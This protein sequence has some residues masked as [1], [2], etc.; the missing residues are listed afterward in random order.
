MLIAP[1]S[2]QALDP[3][4]TEGDIVRGRLDIAADDARCARERIQLPLTLADVV[5]L[6]LCNNPQTRSLWAAAR[7]QAAQVGV[8]T[9]AYLP[10][11]SAQASVAQNVVTTGD[12][13]QDTSSSKSVS[14]S[15]SYL[16]Y[17][18]GGRSAS[19]ENARQLL[20]AVNA[21]RDSTLQ[22]AY[23]NAVQAYYALLS[24]RSSV[25]AYQAAEASAQE[26]LSAAQARY[27]AGVATPVDKLQAQTNLSQATLNRISAEGNERNAQGTLAN[28]MGFDA[29]QLFT[30]RE[31]P[32]ATPDP[33][34]EQDIGR[35][36]TQAR[37]QRP[38][39][40]AADAQIRAAEAQ[41]EATRASGRPTLTLG[42]Q[43]AVGSGSGTP[44]TRSSSIGLTLSVPLF[45]G[46]KTTYQVRAAEAQL[47]GKV[48]DRDRVANQIALDV[49]KAYQT[50]LTSSQALRSADDLVA[51][52]EQSG[53]MVL[54]RYKAGVGNILDTLTAQSAL[55][56]AQQQRVSAL[57]NFLY[58][59]F[60][61][62]QAIGE[63]DLTQLENGKP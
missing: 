14:L 2:S 29:T 10:T 45:S 8:S 51:A 12:Q 41:V 44:D 4:G 28:I 22:L 38:D 11:L 61:L 19:L 59:R 62:A 34:V 43:A 49:W 48:A 30:L 3:F 35:L 52:A 6:A 39:L 31:V 18:F 9:A 16:L 54:G 47:E 27:Q 7:A 5:D 36:I 25:Q 13:P 23:L 42:A 56:S 26:S 33:A 53:K 21:T 60:A 55:A 63:L 50:M 37:Q 57:Y 20:V 32:E 24:A 46:F 17:D 58:S 40:V 1:A 15:A